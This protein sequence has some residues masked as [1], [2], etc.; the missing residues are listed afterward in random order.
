[1]LVF[2]GYHSLV[3][4]LSTLFLEL[5]NLLRNILLALLVCQLLRL[6]LLRLGLPLLLGLLLTLTLNLLEWVLTDLLVGLLVK[7]LEGIRLHVLVNVALELGLVALLIIV[8]KSLHVLSNVATKDVLAEG[9]SVELLGLDV[10]TREALLGVRNVETTV[11]STLHGTED[12]GTSGCADETNIEETLEW[13]A[14]F[15][16]LIGSLGELELSISFLNTLESL[17]DTELLEN[18]ASDEKTSAVC[19]GPVGK[20]VGDTVSLELVGVGAGNDLVTDNF[21][22]D[23]LHD[24]VAVGE[25]DN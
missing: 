1:M 14:L 8:G 22:G 11:R 16:I 3:T 9:L 5:G 24:D 4:R 23:D 25:A 21:G 13:P 20:A 12:T 15:T 2:G 18:T 17:V 6:V 7:L 10:V 19:G